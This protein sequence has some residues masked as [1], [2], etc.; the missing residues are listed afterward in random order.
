MQEIQQIGRRTWLAW[1]AA[2]TWA[3]WSELTDGRG[4]PGW[5][6]ALGGADLATRVAQ[7]QT[8]DPVQPFRVI[9]DFVNAYVLVRG[10]EIA[11]VDT[12][13]PNN[14]AKFAETIKAAGLGWDAVGH[15]LLTHYHPDH[16]G[17]MGEVLAAAPQARVYAGAADIPQIKSPRA[18]IAVKD[19]EEVFGLQIIATAGH[20]PGHISVLDPVGSLLVVGD[21]MGNVNHR[22]SGSNPQYTADMAQATQSVKKLAALTFAKA[23]FGHG[24]PIDQDAS[25]AVA[26]LARTL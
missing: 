9:T 5:R 16:V 4:R 25:A 3:V 21:A 7:A 19:G 17:S 18:I 13:L 1:M 2:G 24:D 23:V 22:L 15:V 20:T 11:I 10:K 8:R 26:T 14:G 6:I 12:G